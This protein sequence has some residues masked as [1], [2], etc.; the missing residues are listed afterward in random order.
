MSGISGGH[1]MPGAPPRATLQQALVRQKCMKVVVQNMKDL[2]YVTQRG[3]WSYNP[4]HA[5]GFDSVLLAQNFIAA[6]NLD[7]AAVVLKCEPG[8]L[9][10]LSGAPSRFDR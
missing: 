1:P 10:D 5:W 9:V 6:A 3:D 4:E 2:R 7:E 8:D